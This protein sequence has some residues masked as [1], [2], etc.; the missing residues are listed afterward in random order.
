MGIG[1]ERGIVLAKGRECGRP[2]RHRIPRLGGRCED[3]DCVCVVWSAQTNLHVHFVNGYTGMM[4]H[5]GPT[6]AA[7]V[8]CL[9]GCKTRR[10]GDGSIMS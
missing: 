5:L 6:I 10:W 8:S 7:I 4:A 2:G 1:E 9:T 3:S